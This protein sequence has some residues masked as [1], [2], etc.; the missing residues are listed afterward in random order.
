MAKQN[1]IDKALAAL[2]A[3]RDAIDAAIAELKAV[4]AAK[5]TRVRKSKDEA[6]VAR[7]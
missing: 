4:Q 3:K 5:P 2:I 6:A 1:Q 7:T